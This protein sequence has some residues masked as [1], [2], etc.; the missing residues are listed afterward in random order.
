[1]FEL[2]GGVVDMESATENAVYVSQ[3]RIAFRRRHIFDQHVATQRV[4]L[5]S[6]APDV[7][8]MNI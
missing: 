6:Q 1:M 8:I 3:N 5:R 7:Q 4:R 2:D